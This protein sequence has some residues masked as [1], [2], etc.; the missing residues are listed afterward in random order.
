MVGENELASFSKD[1]MD[2]VTLF[3]DASHFD[4]ISMMP[5]TSICTTLLIAGGCWII[6]QQNKSPAINTSINNAYSK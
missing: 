1:G 6:E 2:T 5:P 4:D 3:L